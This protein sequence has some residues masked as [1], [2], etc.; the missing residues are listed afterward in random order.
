MQGAPRLRLQLRLWLRLRPRVRPRAASRHRSARRLGCCGLPVVTPAQEQAVA[1][2]QLLLPLRL[3]R[4]L[5]RHHVA[6]TMPTSR[7]LLPRGVTRSKMGKHQNEASRR[8]PN[9]TVSTAR[10]TTHPRQKS[11]KKHTSSALRTLSNTH[12]SAGMPTA[13]QEATWRHGHQEQHQAS[14]AALRSQRSASARHST[15]VIT[16]TIYA[17]RGTEGGGVGG[18]KPGQRHATRVRRSARRYV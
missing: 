10:P 17:W 1:W 6:V 15:C 5:P 9:A 4:L 12:V 14:S 11:N 3:P 16:S 18:D 2:I 7:R 13:A 8:N